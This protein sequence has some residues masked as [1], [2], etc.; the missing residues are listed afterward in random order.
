R[1]HHR[2]MRLRAASDNSKLHDETTGGPMGKTSAGQK[3]PPACQDAAED[4]RA[5]GD[6]RTRQRA[7]R[8][9]RRRD[10]QAAASP[11]LRAA[12][13]APLADRHLLR[14]GRKGERVVLRSEAR[15]RDG[16]DEGA[17]DLRPAYE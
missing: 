8:G 11:P 12:H 4:R 3:L 6:R 16:V 7:I 14:A 2:G 5:G 9:W 1:T 15:F 13:A 17:M 10:G